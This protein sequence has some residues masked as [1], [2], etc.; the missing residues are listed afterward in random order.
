MRVTFKSAG[1]AA[2]I[3]AIYTAVSADVPASDRP[4]AGVDWS[5]VATGMLFAFAG[6]LLFVWLGRKFTGN[7]KK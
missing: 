3:L 4:T 5:Y 2:A 6:A 7:K 1:A